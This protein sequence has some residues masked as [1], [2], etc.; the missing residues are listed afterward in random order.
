MEPIM[1]DIELLQEYATQNS[2]EAFATLVSRHV[3][4]V[5]SV[6][7]RQLNNS[8]HAEEVT[9]AVF[10]ILAKRAGSLRKGTIIS[11]W[12]YQTSRLT[13]RNY[14]RGEIRRQRREQEA[15]MQSLSN[16][17]EPDAWPQIAP[18]LDDAMSHL[19]QKDRDAIALR[20]FEGKN[21]RD[22]GVNLGVSEDAAKMRVGRAVE[23]LRGFFMKRGVALSATLVGSAM[24][25]NSVQAAPAGLVTSATIAATKGISLTAST[26][27]LI[28]G[29]LK[30]MAWTK[31]KIGI[32]ASA[33]A[34]LTAGTATIAVVAFT[35]DSS[36]DA[37]E[38]LQKTEARYAALSTFQ[39]TGKTT[40]AFEGAKGS[41]EL[42]PPEANAA[43]A[44]MANQFHEFTIKMARPDLYQVAWESKVHPAYT[45]LG[46]VW[47]AGEGDFAYLNRKERKMKDRKTSFG[48]AAGVSGGA[49]GNLPGAFFG[50][51]NENPLTTF[52]AATDLK[53]EK[54]ESIG[55]IDCFVV[56]RSKEFPKTDQAMMMGGKAHLTMWIGKK[57]GLMHQRRTITDNFGVTLPNGDGT[58]S[59]KKMTMTERFTD[60]VVNKPIPKAEFAYKVPK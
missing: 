1:D 7:L 34:L 56:S 39:C 10:V 51:G 23:K 46:A 40:T 17:T 19:G 48:T 55:G 24:L 18:L 5:Y 29:T 3:N 12:L 9:Q 25:A 13:A 37:R 21:L 16:E 44:S 52:A 30:I 33:V 60:I 28:K 53:R 26:A 43:M 11:G 22:V 8:H 41:G 38:I 15:Y 14:L 20:F 57:D 54:D 32:A 59:A 4:L 49:T 47:S 6:A 58:L 45:N 35:P 31:L 2:E 42:F 36:V 50:S 27:T